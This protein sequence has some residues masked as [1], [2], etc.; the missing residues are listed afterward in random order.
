MKGNA[1]QMVSKDFRVLN[2]FSFR[3]F[4]LGAAVP[5]LDFSGPDSSSSEYAVR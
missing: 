5:W 2:C 1:F 4:A 3:N